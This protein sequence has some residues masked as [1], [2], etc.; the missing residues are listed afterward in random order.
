MR[1]SGI[2]WLV[3]FGTLSCAMTV[4]AL[5]AQ[6]YVPNSYLACFNSSEADLLSLERSMS[7][8]INAFVQAGTPVTFSGNSG[9]P[10][11]F[12]VASSAALLFSPDLGSGPGTLQPGTSSDTFTATTATA[13]PGILIYWDASFSDATLNG[14][15]GLTPKTYTTHV[16]TFTVASPPSIEAETAAKKKQE[17]A[18]IKKKQEEAETE[19]PATAS[20]SLDGSTITVQSSGQAA[21]KLTCAGTSTCGGKLTLTV[22]GRARKGKKTKT[23][24]IGTASFS[25]PAGKTATVDVTLDGAGRALLS[26][27]HRRLSATLTVLKSSPAPSRTRSES[28]RLVL[29][30]V[31]KAKK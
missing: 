14:C 17:E 23:K 25:I 30:K 1:R 4:P 13:T 21:V 20:V 24:T 28:V 29:R 10:V 26:A 5:P 22:K 2:G 19:A 3:A 16:C 27:A 15:E 6:G 11:T 9:A 12:V 7:P 31:S 8:A 18:A